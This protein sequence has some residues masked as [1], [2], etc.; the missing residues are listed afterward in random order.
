MNKHEILDTPF[1][2]SFDDFIEEE[3]KIIWSGQPKIHDVFWDIFKMGFLIFFLYILKEV[4]SYESTFF[5][6][7][8]I[9][10]LIQAFLIYLKNKKRKQTFYAITPTRV[11]FQF[12]NR[13][14]HQLEFDKIDNITF[15]KTRF[16]KN[17][18]TISLLLKNSKFSPF[19]IYSTKNSTRLNHPTFESIENVQEVAE[20]IIKAINKKCRNNYFPSICA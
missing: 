12:P 9:L 16:N 13:K 11:L 4:S 20:L 3:E 15:T 17:I 19:V 7:V 18:G 1:I 8:A 5:R 2:D 6:V 10:V 14:I